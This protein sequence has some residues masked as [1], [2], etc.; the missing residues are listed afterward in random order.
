MNSVKS[1]SGIKIKLLKAKALHMLTN[2][3]LGTVDPY[4]SIASA[5]L[6]FGKDEVRVIIIT[7]SNF[8]II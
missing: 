7:N 8:L 5:M 6:L 2:W 4:F 1:S 3:V